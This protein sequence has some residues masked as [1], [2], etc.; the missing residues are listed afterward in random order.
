MLNLFKQTFDRISL[1]GGLRQQKEAL[2]L[3][4]MNEDLDYALFWLGLVTGTNYEY[5]R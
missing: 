4:S 2:S 3:G 5:D 1:I